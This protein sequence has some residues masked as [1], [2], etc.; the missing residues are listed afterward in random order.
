MKQTIEAYKDYD[1]IVVGGGSAGCAAAYAAGSS[2]ARTLM[3]EN[4]GFLGGMGTAAGLSI[5]INYLYQKR[6][7]SGS[8][9]RLIRGDLEQQGASYSAEGG[10]V[11]VYEPEALKV[12]FE[13]RL[14]E[15]GVSIAYHSTLL[16]S[17]TEEAAPL[18]LAGSINGPLAVMP[19]LP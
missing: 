1:C 18:F 4:N 13:T 2:G 17:C 6:D 15:V 3:V 14:Q 16:C 19:Q 5:Y 9:Y 10:N 7:L 12:A 11:D 8:F